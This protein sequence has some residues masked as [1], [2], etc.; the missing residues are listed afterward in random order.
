MDGH[1]YLFQKQ[2]KAFFIDGGKIPDNRCFIKLS[3]KFQDGHSPF[4]LIESFRIKLLSIP[5]Q[6]YLFEKSLYT[7]EKTSG[8]PFT[9]PIYLNGNIKSGNGVFAICRSTDFTIT[10]SPPY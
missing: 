7:Y 8:D 2:L 9:E 3:T 5:K 10:F 4:H 1:H 6:L